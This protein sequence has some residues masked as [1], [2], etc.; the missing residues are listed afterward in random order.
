MDPK[1]IDFATLNIPR[2]VM[3]FVAV[4]QWVSKGVG[5]LGETTIRAGFIR[6]QLSGGCADTSPGTPRRRGPLGI[7]GSVIALSCICEDFHAAKIADAVSMR[8]A[9]ASPALAAAWT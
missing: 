7:F 2:N 9:D 4:L 6:D 1:R 5:N 3:F 8:G